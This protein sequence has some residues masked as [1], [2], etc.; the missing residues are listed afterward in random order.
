MGVNGVEIT[1][2]CLILRMLM[3]LD[4]ISR[5]CMVVAVGGVAKHRGTVD[6]DGR[7]LLFGTV[8][9]AG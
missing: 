3:V 2:V 5:V 8:R 4:I 1:A 6:L 9:V 7:V